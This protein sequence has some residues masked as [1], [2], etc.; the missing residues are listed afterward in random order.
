MCVCMCIHVYM[1]VC[2]PVGGW[3]GEGVGCM[4]LCLCDCSE[5]GTLTACG[6]VS[7]V[8]EKEVNVECKKLAV[9]GLSLLESVI[10]KVSG[11]VTVSLSLSVSVFY[12]CINCVLICCRVRGLFSCCFITLTVFECGLYVNQNLGGK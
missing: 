7:G 6:D 11:T 12:Q 8:A 1:C 2:V 4:P 3:V 10:A 9:Q 5:M